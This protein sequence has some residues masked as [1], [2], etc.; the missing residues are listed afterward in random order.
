M[1]GWLKRTPFPDRGR[2]RR[3]R[4]RR[5]PDARSTTRRATVRA[6]EPLR[7]LRVVARP[8]ALDAARWAP[9]TRTVLRLAPDDAFA[10]GAD[11]PSRSATRT[12]SSNRR[13]GFAGVVAARSTSSSRTTS[14]GRSRRSGPPSPRAH[15]RRPGQAVAARTTATRC[16]RT[17]ARL[18]RRARGPPPMS[19]YADTAASSAAA[20]LA[21]AEGRLRR[22]DR[23][24]RRPWPLDRLLPRDAPRDHQRRGARGRLHRVRQ[25]R[26]QHDDHP[27]ELRDPRGGPLLPALARDVPGPR[28]RDGRRDPPP[29]QGHLLDRPHRDGDARRARARA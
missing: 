3:P 8:A 27:G 15:R 26:S 10:I 25:H 12:R 20:W 23:R 6:L 17:A 21:R 16:S 5:R 29:D 4:G 28:G 2:D 1:L 24:R 19:D 9:A 22:R 18:R 11:G 13:P 14:S 7:G